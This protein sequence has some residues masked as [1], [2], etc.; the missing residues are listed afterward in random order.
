MFKSCHY[1]QHRKKKCVRPPPSA[2]TSDR[3]CLA[4]Q[5]LD[6]PCEVGVRKASVKRQRKSQ[7]IASKLYSTSAA[8]SDFLLPRRGVRSDTAVER[9]SNGDCQL[10]RPDTVATATKIIITDSH[11]EELG[12]LSTGDKYRRI[13]HC[14]FPF[15]PD[16]LLRDDIILR[17]PVLSYCIALAASL[18][19][20]KECAGLSD[21]EMQTLVA[22]TEKPCLDIVEAAGLMLLLPRTQLGP[23]IAEKAFRA[24][25][26]SDNP[27]DIPVPISV[28]TLTAHTWLSLAGQSPSLLDLSPSIL[29]DYSAGLDQTTFA[30][31]YLKLTHLAASFLRLRHSTDQE[32]I[33]GDTAQAWARLEYSCL[34][35]VAQM[36][37]EFL[38]VRDEMPASPAAIITHMLQSLIYLQFY[39]YVLCK[40]PEL[41][42]VLGLRPVPGVL[43]FICACSRSIFVCQQQIMEHWT[44]LHNVQAEAAQ[45]MLD[46]WT[47]TKFEN[48]RALLNLWEP[49]P[50]QFESL[51]VEVKKQ[52]GSGPWA[53]EVI[54]GYSVF[55]TFRDVRSLSLEVHLRAQSV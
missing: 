24:V 14:E 42:L 7:Q 55:W 54:D 8:E 30:P 10:L 38:D 52:L 21:L 13:V 22:F 18:S 4:C 2:T 51:Q 49:P 47:L 17:S 26:Q 35:N 41:G 28:A 25:F 40:K 5:H 46:L 9:V 1:C 11:T 39:G 32:G 34:L 37:S 3:R 23:G 43:H 33:A 16:D 48:C 15:I 20:Q 29:L 36:P 19:L 53:I 45:I 31:H 27:S 44:L 6:V 50:N 12:R